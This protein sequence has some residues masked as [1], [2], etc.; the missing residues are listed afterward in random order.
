MLISYLI[1]APGY[2][3]KSIN[4]DGKKFISDGVGEKNISDIF[5]MV[6]AIFFEK[7]KWPI[8]IENKTYPIPPAKSVNLIVTYINHSTFLIQVDGINIITDPIFSGRASPFSFVGPQRVR[9]PGFEIKELPTIDVILISHNHYD[10]LDKT[11]ILK[12]FEKQKDKPPQ[13]I[14]PLGN[15][16]LFEKWEIPNSIDLDWGDEFKFAN[17]SFHL[18]PCRHWS[19]RGLF[20]RM[21][22]LW[23]AFVIKSTQGNI[24]FAGDT[25]YGEHFLKSEKKFGPMRLSLLPIGAYAPRWFMEKQHMSPKE[26]VKAHRDLKSELSIGMH[27]GTFQLAFE[28]IDEPSENLKIERDINKIPSDAFILLDFG[29]SKQI[30]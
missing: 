1:S 13:L 19:A 29:E 21:K 3:G 23:G 26:A 9:Q 28:G 20:D 14:A 15:K 6:R 8:Y 10:H 27:Y 4:F 16:K 11:S 24:Y 25:G 17:L 5:K 2:D 18:E 12:I 7:Q 30:P 22:T